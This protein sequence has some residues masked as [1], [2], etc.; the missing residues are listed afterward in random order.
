MRFFA[1]L[2]LVTL[3]G[4]TGTALAAEAANAAVDPSV[5]DGAKAVF[6]AVMH[7]QWWAAAALSVVLLM[8]AA[9]KYMPASWKEGTKGDIVGVAST[10]LMAFAG[11]VAT[12]AVAQPAGAALTGAVALTALK[13]GFAA[14]GGYTIVHKLAGWLSAWGA[15]PAWAGPILKLLA[16]VVGSNAVIKKAETAGD[17]AVEAK[18][19]SGMAG[20]RKIVEIE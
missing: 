1:L 12:W 10:F 11:A 20:D 5:F 4:F 15:L 13:I 19:P 14:I 2:I 7:G 8:A 17:K 18:P 9:R 3:F 6:D 16:M